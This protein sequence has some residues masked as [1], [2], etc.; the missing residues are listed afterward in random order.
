ML[1]HMEMKGKFKV[2]L[3]PLVSAMASQF[4]KK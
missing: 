2:A 3:A 4:Y 1:A